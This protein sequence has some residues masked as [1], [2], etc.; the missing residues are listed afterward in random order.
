MSKGSLRPWA[1]KHIVLFKQLNSST[2]FIGNKIFD[3]SF[4]VPN[5]PWITN[6]SD[7][8]SLPVVEAYRLNVCRVL[9]DRNLGNKPKRDSKGTKSR[10][11]IHCLIS[12]I[13]LTSSIP[14][15]VKFLTPSILAGKLFPNVT[16]LRIRSRA[17]SMGDWWKKKS[18]LK[19]D[20]QMH[21]EP[22][23][24]SALWTVHLLPAWCWAQSPHPLPPLY[25]CS[26][27]LAISS[28]YLPFASFC[29]LQALRHPKPT[30][31]FFLTILGY[32]HP[33]P[34]FSHLIWT[35]EKQSPTTP[36]KHGY[37]PFPLSS[38]HPFSI[39]P[40]PRLGPGRPVAVEKLL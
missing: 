16:F 32:S 13:N 25:H 37:F 3:Q 35:S 18:Q 2:K 31:I 19:K 5:V 33:H 34:P 14:K 26:P 30:A 40:H 21:H 20:Y 23:G 22:K 4:S 29:S 36:L 39:Q 7:N 6:G 38:W 1:P 15:P 28:H 17:V 12:L 11:H 27:S 24:A 10:R 8:I 9:W